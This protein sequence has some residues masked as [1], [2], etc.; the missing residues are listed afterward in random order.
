M[1]FKLFLHTFYVL[2]LHPSGIYMAMV[3]FD[4]QDSLAK[5]MNAAEMSSVATCL[6]RYS[7]ASAVH[8]ILYSGFFS[9]PARSSAVHMP[10]L[11]CTLS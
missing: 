9:T 3:Y 4:L 11:Q 10:V 6:G 1:I 7:G 5:L 2:Y 8:T